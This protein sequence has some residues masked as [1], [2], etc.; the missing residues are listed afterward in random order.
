MKKP[1]EKQDIKL[2]ELKIN[3]KPDSDNFLPA[4]KFAIPFYLD[5][6]ESKDNGYDSIYFLGCPDSFEN[7]QIEF[8]MGGPDQKNKSHY[9]N[10][11]AVSSFLDFIQNEDISVK[12]RDS[13][14]F[15]TS[16]NKEEARLNYKNLP[17]NFKETDC[18]HIEAFY[19]SSLFYLKYF[20]T[21]GKTPLHR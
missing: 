21:E 17:L 16:V 9:I 19:V 2:A 10:L 14:I 3:L 7:S 13:M 18:K 12:S 8:A 15:A 20:L 11:F 1:S 4:I 5:K 6:A